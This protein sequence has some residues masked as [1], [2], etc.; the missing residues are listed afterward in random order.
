MEHRKRCEDSKHFIK[1]NMRGVRQT[2]MEFHTNEMATE[3]Q[4]AKKHDFET[5]NVAKI[6]SYLK[7]RRQEEEE[8]RLRT[9]QEIEDNKRPVG[10]RVVTVS[11]QARVLDE[12]RGRKAYCEQGIK[13]MSVT[14]YTTRA[15]N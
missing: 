6:P 3:A 9:L 12:L 4:K 2:Q 8:E 1:A 5:R 10:T 7:R 15:Q 13:N 11:E 14:L